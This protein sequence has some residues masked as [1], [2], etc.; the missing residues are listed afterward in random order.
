MEAI[1]PKCMISWGFNYEENSQLAFCN[2]LWSCTW[3]S[4]RMYFYSQLVFVCLTPLAIPLSLFSQLCLYSWHLSHQVIILW[5]CYLWFQSIS[6]MRSRSKLQIAAEDILTTKLMGWFCSIHS[7]MCSRGTMRC[8][9]VVKE[10]ISLLLVCQ[11][12]TQ[13]ITW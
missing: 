13:T 1:A 5:L 10:F 9:V 8:T 2:A 3:W 4:Q 7:Q 12:Q 6:C 11:R